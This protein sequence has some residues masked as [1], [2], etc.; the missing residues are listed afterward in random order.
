M[1]R[2]CICFRRLADGAICPAD[3]TR[4]PVEHAQA[5]VGESPPGYEGC[6][7]LGVG[8]FATTWGV[9]DESGTRLALKWG[10]RSTAA[11][12]IRFEQES[13]LLSEVGT[14]IAPR[15]VK[16]GL[17]EG[18]PY[19]LQERLS[20]EPLSATLEKL[21]SALPIESIV[22]TGSWI[23]KA[24]QEVHGKGIVHRDLKPDNIFV[25]EEG[26]RLIDFGVS[27]YIRDEANERGAGTPQYSAPEMWRGGSN[28]PA[29][30]VYSWG[31][32]VYE[33]LC[34][35]LPFV[36]EGK[37]IQY[38]HATLRP[39]RPS[40]FTRLPL[41]LEELVLVSLSKSPD[42]RPTVEELLERLQSAGTGALATHSSD[43][44]SSVSSVPTVLLAAELSIDACGLQDLSQQFGADIVHHGPKEIRLAWPSD[45]HESMM[46]LAQECAQVVIERGAKCPII[47]LVRALRSSYRG[48][49]RLFGNQLED[50]SWWNRGTSSELRISPEAERIQNS[51]QAQIAL[52]GQSEVVEE[53]VAESA[54]AYQEQA[55][56]SVCIFGLPGVGT[57]RLLVEAKREI[58]E[59][60]RATVFSVEENS[61]G[62][63]NAET[64]LD[65]CMS[66]PVLLA[67]DRLQEYSAETL[68]LLEYLLLPGES[69]A[70][71]LVATASDTFFEGRPQWGL[72][73]ENYRRISIEPL[74][75]NECCELFQEL[76]RPAQY[77]PNTVLS[78]LASWCGG[79]PKSA[80][81]LAAG[82]ARDGFIV[83][84]GADSYRLDTERLAALPSLP[85]DQWVASRALEALGPEVA[86]F[87]MLS[88]LMPPNF[89]E[90]TVWLVS[91]KVSF[92]QELAESSVALFVLVQ[93]RVLEKKG[94]DYYFVNNGVRAVLSSRYSPERVREV[95]E[96]ALFVWSAREGDHRALQAISFHGSGA[97]KPRLAV[98]A[99]IE[100]GNW[101]RQCHRPVEA[102]RYYSDSLSLLDGLPD[103]KGLGLQALQGLAWA[104]YRIDRSDDAIRWALEAA[105]LAKSLR[106]PK[107]EILCLLEAATALDWAQRLNESAERVQ[108]AEGIATRTGLESEVLVSLRLALGRGR[109][110]WR[111][112]DLEEAVMELQDAAE[113]ACAAGDFDTQVVALLL[114]APALVLQG[115]DKLAEARYEELFALCVPA[116]DKFHL[117]A[118]YGNRM[119]LWSA[120]KDPERARDD[121]RSAKLL[122]EQIGH[123]SPERVALYNLGED[124]Y[125]S[126][127]NDE[128]AFTL[129]KRARVL[130]DRFIQQPVAEDAL[131]VAR[132]ALALENH[133]DAQEAVSWVETTVPSAELSRG[134]ELF[135][136]LIHLA[137][138][139]KASAE[140]WNTLL[141]K[142]EVEMAGDDLLEFYYW[143][144]RAGPPDELKSEEIKG[145]CN[146]LLVE[147]PIWQERFETLGIYSE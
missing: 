83:Q 56:R 98:E 79:L 71:F 36:G 89:D 72:R 62:P 135:V 6:E 32:I 20:G 19:I 77:I 145:A 35:R 28:C 34:M 91:E 46:D 120:R 119:F 61:F 90:E 104:G 44:S 103:E 73:C 37:A 74:G 106:Q 21:E 48:H 47:H 109:S 125:W 78:E 43:N 102:H 68:D 131:L 80:Y 130:A 3:G 133:A 112:G 124:L 16:T 126:G 50:I 18:R 64:I 7:L 93:A 23:A 114:L 92:S 13:T 55:A 129:A 60:T 100:L 76:L 88:S 147:N 96:K 69:K 52:I 137:S 82:L 110:A 15:L 10:R 2:C 41:A 127:E 49:K 42:A 121:L 134:S 54:L 40:Q 122:A 30:D 38:E 116:N 25:T 138:N 9:V 17:L 146:A 84:R 108:E 85:L 14:P 86:A 128:E 51:A 75:S 107:D 59:E 144:L 8:G 141:E 70:I 65:A 81:E 132:V 39:P 1:P 105:N 58:Q 22:R 139:K 31:V 24:M 29:L 12:R 53:L 140:S 11:A 99:S 123:P 4:A 101:E 97:G 26:C 33:L 142:A 115:C 57:T 87:A 95:H 111:C 27:G 63:E 67:L 5:I 45:S 117:C 136:G 113:G 143:R 66:G 94:G 118:A